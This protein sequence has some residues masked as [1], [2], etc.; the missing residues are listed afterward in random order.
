VNLVLF[1][2]GSGAWQLLP[3]RTPARQPVPRGPDR[4]DPGRLH[5]LARSRARPRVQR[6]LPR[7]PGDELLPWVQEK[8]GLD[9][10]AA[11]P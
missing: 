8:Y 4:P 6:R 10:A 2:D 11:G 3:S 7:V 1:L 5:R 9:F